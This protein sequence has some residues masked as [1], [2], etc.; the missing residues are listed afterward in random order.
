M[1]D[2]LLLASTH[3][4]LVM[5][6]PRVCAARIVLLV[7][8]TGKSLRKYCCVIECRLWHFVKVRR[9]RILIKVLLLMIILSLAVLLLV[10]HL[11]LS[12]VVTDLIDSCL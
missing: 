4:A 9:I 12:L 3:L 2:E 7:G 1:L 5:L 10:N 11:Q 6:R 8:I